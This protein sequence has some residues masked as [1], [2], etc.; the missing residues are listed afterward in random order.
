VKNGY[1]IEPFS[2]E[3]KTA[4]YR[5]VWWD[6]MRLPVSDFAGAG[7]HLTR[8]FE[9]A[10]AEQ[11]D[12]IESS[13]NETP[14]IIVALRLIHDGAVAA[15]IGTVILPLDEPEITNEMRGGWFRVDECQPSGIADTYELLADDLATFAEILDEIRAVRESKRHADIAVALR[16]FNQAYER[17]KQEDIL[18]DLVVA[19]ES[20]LLAGIAEKEGLAFRMALRG[21]AL[22]RVRRNPEDTFTM[23][24]QLYAARSKIVHEGAT[25]EDLYSAQRR[26]NSKLR[27]WWDRDAASTQKRLHLGV[28]ADTRQLTREAIREYLRRLPESKGM[29]SINEALDRE[30]KQALTPLPSDERVR[31]DAQS[32]R[33]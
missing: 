30:I 18:I 7:F 23:F 5:S 29:S 9:H 28:T 19:L 21:A 24:N 6:A 33:D 31:E 13:R 12:M 8:T 15:P 25:L 11:P 16:R 1:A 27:F 22:L 20:S 10:R 4:V 2:P 17:T 32:S 3:L 26:S 14:D